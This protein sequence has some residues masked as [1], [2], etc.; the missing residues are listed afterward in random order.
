[1]AISPIRSSRCCSKKV[2]SRAAPKEDAGRWFVDM[3]GGGVLCYYAWCVVTWSAESRETRGCCAFAFSGCL[4]LL[5]WW[6]GRPSSPQLNFPL[7]SSGRAT[8]FRRRYL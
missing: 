7:C 2:F 8:Y 1:M 3:V 4:S 6:G 5:A